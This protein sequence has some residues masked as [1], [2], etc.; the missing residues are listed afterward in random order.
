MESLAPASSGDLR[1]AIAELQQSSAELRK[2][3][4]AFQTSAP[5]KTAAQ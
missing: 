2:Q 4:D 1:A 5:P 3:L